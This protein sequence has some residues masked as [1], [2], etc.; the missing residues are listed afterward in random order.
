MIIRKSTSVY[1][2][3]KGIDQNEK[4]IVAVITKQ[5]H[6]RFLKMTVVQSL[7]EKDVAFEAPKM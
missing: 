3:Y 2:P 4:G 1:K 7:S 5:T 6:S